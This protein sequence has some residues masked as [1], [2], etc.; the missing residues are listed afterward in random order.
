MLMFGFVAA[1]FVAGALLML[2]PPLL[3]PPAARRSA[4]ALAVTLPAVAIALYLHLGDPGAAAPATPA[5]PADASRHE[6]APAQIQQMA[7]TLAERLQREPADANGWLT[8]A[9]SYT[10][11]GRY[12][13]AAMA[14]RRVAELVP[15]NANVLADLADLLAMAQGKRFAGEPMRWIQQ[16]LDVDPRHA[17]A[18]ALAGSAAFETQD[19]DSARSHWERLLAV[20]PPDSPMQRSVRGSLAEA[21]RLEGGGAATP[22][23][24]AMAAT[25][26]SGQVVLAPEL[27][28]RVAPGDTLF[29]FARAAQG[30]RLPL[31]VSRR[32]AN[33]ERFEFSLD[34]SMAMPGGPKL[35]SAAEVVVG[36][37]ISRSGSATPQSGDLVGSSAPVKPGSAGIVVRIDRVQPAAETDRPMAA[38]LP[39]A[40]AGRDN[41]RP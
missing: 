8:L 6:L 15:R 10:A 26:V 22:A 2:L 11:L 35:S 39:S 19:Y 28:G 12:R 25:A 36:A 33:S 1:L 38:V 13:D 41:A 30:P 18:L 4:L 9:R 14:M 37:R 5:R 24:A 32:S 27:A 40:G 23:A 17:K 7:T 34:D 16:A 31:A 20:L 21:T 29:V 3:R